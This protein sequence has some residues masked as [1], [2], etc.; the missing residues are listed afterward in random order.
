MRRTALLLGLVIAVPMV[1]SAQ[2]ERNASDIR[3]GT[4]YSNSFF[5]STTSID[6]INPDL[7]FGEIIAGETVT[8][9]IDSP[10]AA[11]F[12]ITG[13]PF[14]DV[15]IDIDIP[16]QT[17]PNSGFLYLT[18][19]DEATCTQNECRIAITYTFGF[20]N[21]GG[22]SPDALQAQIFT[23]NPAVFPVRRRTAGGPP[24]PPPTPEIQGASLPGSVPSFLFIYGTIQSFAVNTVGSYSATLNIEI[25]YN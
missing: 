23:I 14:L 12:E 1:L 6:A 3:F 8:I 16:G 15:Y 18:G 5:N 21:S 20:D 7:L 22:T 19:E 25:S 17:A 2:F 24:G 11:I 9:D 13:V 10:D 4:F